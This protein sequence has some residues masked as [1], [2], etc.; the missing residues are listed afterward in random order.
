MSKYDVQF[1]R[2]D[3]GHTNTHRHTDTLITILC[4]PIGGGVTI[5]HTG[6]LK[7]KKRAA[8][9]TFTSSLTCKYTVSQK[10]KTPNSGP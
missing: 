8:K 1:G 9:N 10:N 6:I 4:S 2:C 3:S 7:V 5:T